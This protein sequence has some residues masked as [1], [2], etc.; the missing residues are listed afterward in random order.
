MLRVP[1]HHPR[2][3]LDLELRT[4]VTEPRSIDVNNATWDPSL[5]LDEFDERVWN[6]FNGSTLMQTSRPMTH[7]E[8]VSL[9]KLVKAPTASNTRL[10]AWI[11]RD[12][13]TPATAVF[14]VRRPNLLA[15]EYIVMGTQPSV[16]D[17]G[18]TYFN[19]DSVSEEEGE[20]R[21]PEG[22]AIVPNVRETLRRLVQLSYH[23]YI[24]EVWEP[25]WKHVQEILDL[26]STH[27]SVWDE[28]W[29]QLTYAVPCKKSEL[30]ETSVQ[31]SDTAFNFDAVPEYG[32]HIWFSN[33]TKC[34]VPNLR[35]AARQ[36]FEMRKSCCSA[37]KWT[38][39]W[40]LVRSMNPSGPAAL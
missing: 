28:Q 31:L 29:N 38:P 5:V 34:R 35:A 18:A 39:F 19:F 30:L 22:I 1:F 23:C 7:A 16:L 15:T 17:I 2:L 3:Q 13:F 26:S 6:V 4:S 8:S 27:F 32:G 37:E 36:L 25:F 12:C 20:I 24:H 33:E 14:R 10:L 21:F 40:D 9:L 11:M